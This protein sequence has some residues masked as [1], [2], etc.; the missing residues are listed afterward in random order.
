M[1]GFMH[2]LFF[3]A[4]KVRALFISYSKKGHPSAWWMTFLFFSGCS[5]IGR[6][7]PV[8]VFF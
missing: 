3:V 2:R 8:N 6:S 1:P 4:G 7:H 5:L